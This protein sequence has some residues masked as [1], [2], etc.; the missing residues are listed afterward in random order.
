MVYYIE[1]INNVLK[2]PFKFLIQR[3]NNIISIKTMLKNLQGLF[4][5]T[6]RI[7]VHTDYAHGHS[8]STLYHVLLLL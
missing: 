2:Q 8:L 6:P 3:Y 1:D 5:P 4:Y 7:R